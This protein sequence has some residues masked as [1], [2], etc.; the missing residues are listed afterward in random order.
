MIKLMC[1]EKIFYLHIFL[2]FIFICL[3][4]GCKHTD[5]IMINDVNLEKVISG[6][7]RSSK[8]ILKTIENAL[9]NGGKI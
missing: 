8:C 3:L 9:Q 6:A 1:Q 7:T 5:S 2:L 4:P